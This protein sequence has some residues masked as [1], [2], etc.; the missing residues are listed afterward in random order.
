MTARRIARASRSA[1]RSAAN[2]ERCS[3]SRACRSHH[4][5]AARRRSCGT[6]TADVEARLV[7]SPRVAE[8]GQENEDVTRARA[9][10]DV[11]RL[12]CVASFTSP[13]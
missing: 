8:S 9:H 1:F 11:A 5:L 4:V 6:S 13:A 12:T 3:P 10:V 7:A 2:R